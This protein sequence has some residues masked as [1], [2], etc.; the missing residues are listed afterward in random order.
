M[1]NPRSEYG[2]DRS[3]IEW[4][5][6]ADFNDDWIR[7]HQELPPAHLHALGCVTIYWNS[8]EHSLFGLFCSVAHVPE[9]FGRILVHD[10]DSARIWQKIIDLGYLNL[11]S[12]M[13]SHVQ[14]ARKMFDICKLNRNSYAHATLGGSNTPDKALGLQ[15][16]KGKVLKPVSIDDNIK[17]IRR[18]ADEIEMVSRYI[19]TIGI[20]ITFSRRTQ[21]RSSDEPSPSLGKPKMPKSLR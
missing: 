19:A 1:T 5:E 13:L 20:S 2:L 17:T 21:G 7:T 12:E 16:Q 15:F 9:K 10:M 11:D 6:V 18:V 8:C 3:L 14:H 4:P